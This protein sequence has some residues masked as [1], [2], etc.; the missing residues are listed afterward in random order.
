MKRRLTREELEALGVSGEAAE[1]VLGELRAS[2]EAAEA[3]GQE[4]E[5]LRG[6]LM[7]RDRRER[8][9][10]ALI[11]QGARPE[12]AGL[13]A[14]AVDAEAPG[15]TD[16]QGIAASLRTAYPALF[17]EELPPIHPPEGGALDPEGIRQMSEEEINRNWESV[18]RTLAR[19]NP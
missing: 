7:S 8:L 17:R 16:E 9:R 10:E 2:G 1:R 19:W 3:A 15:E 14:M 4:C 11:R 5:R 6:E 18:K 12:S 13:L